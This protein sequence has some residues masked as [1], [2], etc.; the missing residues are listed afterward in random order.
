MLGGRWNIGRFARVP[1]AAFRPFVVEKRREFL[2]L[3]FHGR[4]QALALGVVLLEAW[5]DSADSAALGGLAVRTA[6]LL[7]ALTA[8]GYWISA[9]SAGGKRASA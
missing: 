8:L 2:G 1:P 5:A 9:W 7:A 3:L 6:G 4:P